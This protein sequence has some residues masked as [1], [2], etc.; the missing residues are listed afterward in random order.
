MIDQIATRNHLTA[1]EALLVVCM[2]W[3]D[4]QFTPDEA[5]LM[6]ELKELLLQLEGEC[7]EVAETLRTGTRLFTVGLSKF[8]D[9]RQ[10]RRLDDFRR[11]RDRREARRRAR[12]LGLHVVAGESEGGEPME[13]AAA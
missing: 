7:G 3:D 1:S 4:R 2:I 9:E 5:T 10:V 6:D 11:E 12:E 13:P 8:L